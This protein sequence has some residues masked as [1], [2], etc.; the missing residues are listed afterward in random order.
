MLHV[1]ELEPNVSVAPL[2]TARQRK[3]KVV[4]RKATLHTKCGE[5]TTRRVLASPRRNLLLNKCPSHGNVSIVRLHDL[6]A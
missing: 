6:V 3:R 4:G 1:Y 2:A 5:V